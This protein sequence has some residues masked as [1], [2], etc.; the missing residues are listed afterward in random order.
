MQFTVL[1]VCV[2]VIFRR[3]AF[4]LSSLRWM[5]LNVWEN[6]PN[7]PAWKISVHVM[8]LYVVFSLI[9]TTQLLSTCLYRFFQFHCSITVCIKISCFRY[10]YSIGLSTCYG[11]WRKNWSCQLILRFHIRL[12]FPCS[13]WVKSITSNSP[14]KIPYLIIVL[15]LLCL[16]Y[17]PVAIKTCGCK[18]VISMLKACPYTTYL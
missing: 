17:A 12:D 6:T 1:I 8:P 16:P 18:M 13:L 7:L 5:C 15:R 14:W 10:P 2:D 4:I 11:I 9:E 3:R